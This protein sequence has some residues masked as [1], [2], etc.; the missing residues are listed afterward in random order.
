[1]EEGAGTQLGLGG[2]AA[3]DGNAAQ[4][5]VGMQIGTLRP[6]P[7]VWEAWWWGKS[8]SLT[9]PNSSS[10]SLLFSSPSLKT[11]NCCKFF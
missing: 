3:I 9:F 7:A 8:I 2:K 10:I 6:L 4:E 1:M 5:N 11:N